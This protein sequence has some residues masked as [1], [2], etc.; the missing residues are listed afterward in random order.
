MPRHHWTLREMQTL[1]Q[2][3]PTQPTPLIAK[4]LGLPVGKVY[5]KAAAMGLSKSKAYLRERRQQDARRLLEHGKPYRYAKG[6]TPPNKGKPMAPET[7][8][9]CAATMFK[10]GGICL[11]YTSPSP[12]D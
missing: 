11:L 9:K 2:R 10:K 1:A 5:A 6:A 4:A 8:A 7:Y 12:R 3:Y